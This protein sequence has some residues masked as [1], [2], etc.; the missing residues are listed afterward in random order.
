MDKHLI[1]NHDTKLNKVVIEIFL[2]FCVQLF[3]KKHIGCR[4]IRCRY[5]LEDYKS[6]DLLFNCQ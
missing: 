4:G 1:R 6:E 3:K 2:K 5:K